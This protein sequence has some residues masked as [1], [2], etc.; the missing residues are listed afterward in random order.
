[1]SQSSTSYNWLS[2]TFH[3]VMAVG[4]VGMLAVGIYMVDMD[5]SPDKFR[6]YGIHKSVGAV[7]LLLAAMRV[8]WNARSPSVPLPGNT[9]RWQRYAARSSHIAL[10]AL[11]LCMP[12]SGWAMS[13]AYGFPVSVF[14]WFT[15]PD[16][17]AANKELAAILKRCHEAGMIAFLVL[18]PVHAGA[19]LLH[20]FYYK[21]AVLKRMLP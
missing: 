6:L 11:M 9:P 18:L 3:W 1:M 4:I 2:K 17:A 5:V 20:H 12:L 21:D 8:I 7:L 10:Y 16:I 13:S 15:L 19:V 14:G